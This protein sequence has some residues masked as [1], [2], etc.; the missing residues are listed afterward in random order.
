ML[1]ER[2]RYETSLSV[3]RCLHDPMAWQFCPYGLDPGPDPSPHGLQADRYNID[4]LDWS[5]VACHWVHGG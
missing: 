1:P 3:I 4:D 2:T 5:L